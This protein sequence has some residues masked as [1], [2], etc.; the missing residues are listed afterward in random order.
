MLILIFTN[1]VSHDG[2]TKSAVVNVANTMYAY[3]KA[4]M[5]LELVNL[6][7][8]VLVGNEKIHFINKYKKDK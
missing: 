8:G 7:I 3:V 4:D 2:Y 1:V 5:M 6:F